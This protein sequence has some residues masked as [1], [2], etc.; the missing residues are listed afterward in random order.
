M[1]KKLKSHHTGSDG[2]ISLRSANHTTVKL[3][4]I[5]TPKVGSSTSCRETRRTRSNTYETFIHSLSTPAAAID[6][7]HEDEQA[8]LTSIIRRN[9]ELI[10]SSAHDAGVPILHKL[11]FEEMLQFEKLTLMPNSTI[12]MAR[13]F[14]NSIRLSIFPSEHKMRKYMKGMLPDTETG[15][16]KLQVDG[17]DVHITFVRVSD[18]VA[19]IQQHIQH[20]SNTSQ[21]VHYYNMPPNVLFI[22][23][24]AD[25]GTYACS[26]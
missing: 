2:T 22:E 11:S 5:P 26:T 16:I 7:Q 1:L 6:N 24:Q 12:R 13:S 10:T 19:F 4:P 14:L 8:Q 23:T 21:L 25:K 3:L 20:L 18:V 15:N 17:E 9:T